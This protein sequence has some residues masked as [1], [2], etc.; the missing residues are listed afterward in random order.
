MILIIQIQI[1]NLDL[2]LTQ[3]SQRG[4]TGRYDHESR[5]VIIAIHEAR[6]KK[7]AF[8]ESRGGPGARGRG[9]VGNGAIL[10]HR[11]PHSHFCYL[12]FRILNFFRRF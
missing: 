5:T 7:K 1:V 3:T 11:R 6:I 8:H 9:P 4:V 10:G 2:L 12:N